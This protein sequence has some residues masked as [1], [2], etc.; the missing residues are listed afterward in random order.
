MAHKKRRKKARKTKAR[1]TK[2]RKTRKHRARKTPKL[3]A[4]ALAGYRRKK[5]ALLNDLY[6]S[7]RR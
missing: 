7:A 5:R 3:S 2:A 1:K 6:K 4:A